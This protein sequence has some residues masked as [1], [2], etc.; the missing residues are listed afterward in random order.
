RWMAERD[1]LDLLRAAAGLAV[2][3]GILIQGTR[4]WTNYIDYLGND[5]DLAQASM[6]LK[7]ADRVFWPY[8]SSSTIGYY[9]G[10]DQYY[11]LATR[12]PLS[13][14]LEKHYFSGMTSPYSADT[15]PFGVLLARQELDRVGLINA[16]INPSTFVAKVKQHDSAV[17]ARRNARTLVNYYHS[18][19][20]RPGNLLI[21]PLG[22]VDQNGE[23]MLY[24]IELG[25]ESVKTI[26][27]GFEQV[28]VYVDGLR[29]ADTSYRR[30]LNQGGIRI[31]RKTNAE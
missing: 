31:L 17:D 28:S 21:E 16:V 13:N 24:Q 15:L 14:I 26:P 8:G 10:F 11:S 18:E 25:E 19:I 30:K 22:V 6:E 7:N 29:Y 5:I 12:G 1:L 9:Q 2:T 3:L 27:S 23:P 20:V 4:S